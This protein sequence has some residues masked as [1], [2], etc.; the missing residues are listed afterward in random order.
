[1]A[2]I[3][4]IKI[5]DNT[6]NIKDVVSTWGIGGTT[7]TLDHTLSAADVLAE[8]GLAAAMHFVG[9][10]ESST[11]TPSAGNYIK[12]RISTATSNN[13]KIIRLTTSGTATEIAAALGDVFSDG[14]KE[15]VCT[16]AGLYN[17]TASS[18][19]MF[20]LLGDEG[21]YALNSISVTGTGEL[22]GGG[23]LTQD[24]TITHKT[25]T[26]VSLTSSGAKVVVALASN[27][28]GHLTS[29]SQKT[30]SSHSYTPAG[31]NAASSVTLTGG[32]TSKLVTTS[33]TGTNGTDTVHDTPTLTY[34]KKLSTTTLHDTPTLTTATVTPYTSKTTKYL[35]TTSI[36]PTNGTDTVHDTPTLTYGKK[37]ETTTITGVSGSTTTHDTPTLNTKKLVT[38]SITGVSGS[39]TTHD[40]PTL[41]TGKLV[42]T[43][44]HDTPSLTFGKKLTTTTVTGTN[45]TDNATLVSVPSGYT[46]YSAKVGT[47]GDEA[48]TLIFSAVTLTGKTLAKVASSATTVATGAVETASSNGTIPSAISAGTPVTVATGSV[49]S[50]GTGSAVGT[51]L[52]A[53]TQVTVPTAAS[54][55]T[56]VA[57]GALG[58]GTTN[59]GDSVGYSL[60]A[61][62]SVNVPTAAGSATTVATG[63]VV[64]IGSGE[65]G[66][67]VSGLTAGTSKTFA[68]VGTA[69]DVFTTLNTTS[70]G[71]SAVI[72]GVSGSEITYATGALTE[73]TATTV[74]TGA[75]E[76]VGSGE[77]GTIVSGLTAGTSKT[78]AK[79]ASSATTVATGSV[80]SDGG[81]ATVATALR[82]GG[83]AAAQTFTGTAAT[84]SHSLS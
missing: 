53:G 59:V 84:L 50:S 82:T 71:G 66:T 27:D 45:G 19:N 46:L 47:S 35:H 11:S 39:T 5:G 34:G 37:L 77:T 41:N 80:A 24:R 78:F 58:T 56:T 29:A 55:A 81:G 25:H 28:Y 72:T 65:T 13:F 26:A 51:S 68:K 74:A 10:A 1:M 33:I 75:V 49:S 52:T 20:T 9:A 4:K 57:T 62:T 69:V 61:G 44:V 36:T 60:T 7:T 2:D 40:T 67:I 6:Y 3:K 31:T 42:T 21:S 38:T 12:A 23:T 48:D 22:S 16:T 8:L 70:S 30:I 15:Y 32:S 79:V 63:G 18:S 76:A 73:G 14:T 17:S 54:S 83:T 43:T 64:N